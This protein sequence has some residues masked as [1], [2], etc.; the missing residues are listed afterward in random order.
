MLKELSIFG[1]R[2]IQRKK[3]KHAELGDGSMGKVLG[4]HT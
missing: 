2:Q 3:L 4:I 1:P